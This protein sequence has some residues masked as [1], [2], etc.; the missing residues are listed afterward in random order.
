M[1]DPLEPFQGLPPLSK[2]AR[3]FLKTTEM[4]EEFKWYLLN[5]VSSFFH[6]FRAVL[7]LPYIFIIIYIFLITL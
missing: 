3:K 5:E 4:I 7:F 2:N 1:V 6:V